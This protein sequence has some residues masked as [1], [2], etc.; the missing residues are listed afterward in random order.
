[1]IHNIIDENHGIKVLFVSNFLMKLNVVYI[2]TFSKLRM[3]EISFFFSSPAS[4]N[5]SVRTSQICGFFFVSNHFP[6]IIIK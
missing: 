3:I 2:S 1:M 6:F 4:M 5:L